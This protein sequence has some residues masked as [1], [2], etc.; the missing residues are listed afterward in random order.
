M[1]FEITLM[2]EDEIDVYIRVSWEALTSTEDS[3]L[4]LIY[5]AGFTE[6]VQTN[7]RKTTRDGLS[8][9]STSY[10]FIRDSSTKDVIAVACWYYQT[11][12]LTIQEVLDTEEK[13]KRKRAEQGPIP[14]INNAMI[15]EFREASMKNKREILAGKAHA[16]LR[17]LATLPAAQRKGAGTAG[18]AWGLRKADELDLPVYLVSSGM[19]RSVYAKHG[20]EEVSALTDQTLALELVG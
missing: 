12:D 1:S 8:D 10:V 2:K 18:L 6:S 15:N 4:S 20:F 13:A 19:G 11:K 7:M 9:P 14:G 3:L 17:V 16:A 5:P